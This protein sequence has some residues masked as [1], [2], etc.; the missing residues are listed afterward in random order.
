MRKLIIVE[1]LPCSGKSTV[2]KHIADVLGM[3]FTDEGS[4]DHPADYEFHAFISEN[5]LAEFQPDEQELIITAAEKRCGGYVVPIGSFC[6]D[7]FDRL[8]THKIYDFLPW[9]TEKPLMLD[10]W[11]SFAE[12]AVNS[13]GHV[14]NCVFLQNPMCETMM[15]FGFDSSVSEGYIRE[16]YDIIRPLEPFV[17]Y[18]KTDNIAAEIKRTVPE[19]GVEWLSGVIDYHCGG[20]YG[21]A[22][23]LSGFEGYVSALEE[24]QRRE[25]AIL[26]HLGIDSIIIENFKTDSKNAYDK[27]L[28]ALSAK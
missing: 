20:E 3:E 21:K 23:G 4:G 12:S 18:L 26:R 25:A 19:R 6:G 16:I 2:S 27:I 11:R 1:G 13:S 15:R 28:A 7:L 24:R 9:E 8:L 17:V 5:E 10:K 22:L 14:F